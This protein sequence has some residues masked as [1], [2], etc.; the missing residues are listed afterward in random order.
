MVYL[1]LKD[2]IWKINNVLMRDNT[3]LYYIEEL[4]NPYNIGTFLLKIII[5]IF[6]M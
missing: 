2:K 3:N 1:L 6:K 4:N 5:Y